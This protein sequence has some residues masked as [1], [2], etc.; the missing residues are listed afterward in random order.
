MATEKG[1]DSAEIVRLYQDLPG[2]R[3][4]SEQYFTFAM[5]DHWRCRYCHRSLLTYEEVYGGGIVYEH[6]LPQGK[7]SHLERVESN[8]VCS[9]HACNVLKGQGTLTR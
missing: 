8:W 7:Y 5:R 1:I 6:L 4:M 9:R 2:K 3:F